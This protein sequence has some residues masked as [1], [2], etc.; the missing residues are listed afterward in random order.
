MA[1]LAELRGQVRSFRHRSRTWPRGGEEF[2]E[3]LEAPSSDGLA[4]PAPKSLRK[5]TGR[6]PGR[7]KGQPGATM[8]LSEHPDHVVRHEPACCGR[9]GTD[10]A[11]APQR[12]MTG[13]R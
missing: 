3:L 1:E 5:K 2:E 10:L 9:C 11:G 7:P 12:G 4:K 13:G 8:R 6:K